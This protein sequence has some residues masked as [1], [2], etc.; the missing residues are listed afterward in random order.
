MSSQSGHT[1]LELVVVMG[2]LGIL[3]L[4]ISSL[5]GIFFESSQQANLSATRDQ[6]V[7]DLRRTAED[8][9]ALRASLKK[10]GNTSFFNCACGGALCENLIASP[11]N[12]YSA[13]GELQSPRY[14]NGNGGPCQPTDRGCVIR[15][16]T[17][18]LAQCMPDLKT[19]TQLPPAD[20]APA[21]A[22]VIAV[23]FQVDQNPLSNTG[24]VVMVRNVSGA[25]YQQVKDIAIPG[26]CL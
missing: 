16:Q 7:L 20:C 24:G 8:P 17:T 1:L 3:A 19:T 4:A 13:S 12:V 2:L 21:A 14:Y 11:L 22:E 6:I 10:P 5:T 25:V 15:V 9:R 26:A 23:L 18:F